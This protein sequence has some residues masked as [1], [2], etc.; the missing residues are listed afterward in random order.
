MPTPFLR[1]ATWPC[2]GSSAAPSTLCLSRLPRRRAPRLLAADDPRLGLPRARR[3]VDV[4]RGSC[5]RSGRGVVMRRE[6]SLRGQVVL[7]RPNPSPRGVG[8]VADLAAPGT[9][10]PHGRGSESRRRAGAGGNPSPDLE[11]RDR[12]R[13]SGHRPGTLPGQVRGVGVRPMRGLRHALWSTWDNARGLGAGAVIAVLRSL[14]AE[15]RARDG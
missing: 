13:S 15:R 14:R 9:F 2:S 8:W 4:P 10:W 5:P 6:G 1:A 3:A 11:G 12:G 7:R